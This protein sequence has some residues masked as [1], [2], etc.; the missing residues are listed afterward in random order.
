MTQWPTFDSFVPKPVLTSS[1]LGTTNVALCYGCAADEIFS[2][3]KLSLRTTMVAHF[4]PESNCEQHVLCICYKCA[5][6][7]HISGICTKWAANYL[8]IGTTIVSQMQHNS[9]ICNKR[10]ICTISVR[11][12]SVCR[13]LNWIMTAS[14]FPYPC[15]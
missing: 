7:L 2:A 8:Y 1:L 12:L 3:E 10:S 11:V 14:K 4:C 9:C 15:N 13:W 5:Q 6:L